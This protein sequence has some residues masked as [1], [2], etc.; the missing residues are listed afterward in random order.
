MPA[1]HHHHGPP[2]GQSFGTAFAIG[3]ALNTIFVIV[4]VLIG[5]L[6]GSMALV[7]DGIH[8]FTDVIALVLAW[9]GYW[10]QS[11]KPRGRFTYGFGAVS[12]QSAVINAFLLVAGVTLIFW[13]SL[14]RLRHP[15]PVPGGTLMAVAG[16]GILINGATAL[17]FMRGSKDDVNI[18]GA[19]IHMAADAGVSLGVVIAGGIVVL[20]GWTIVDPLVGI[21]IAVLVLFSSWELLTESLNLALHA[22]PKNVDMTALAAWLRSRPGVAG[23]HDLHVWPLS[24]NKTALSVHLEMPDVQET[25]EL[26]HELGHELHEHFGIEHATIQIESAPGGCGHGC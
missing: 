22:A 13:E 24:T 17:L 8:N 14:S 20:T 16:I 26:L 7:A 1:H 11:R 21:A 9:T 4:E 6:A 10:F 25:D 12:I 23:F 2:A 15:E 5:F 19:F 3:I 18:R